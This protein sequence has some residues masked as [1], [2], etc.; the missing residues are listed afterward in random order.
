MRMLTLLCVAL[1]VPTVFSAPPKKEYFLFE[2]SDGPPQLAVPAPRM[3]KEEQQKQLI[4]QAKSKDN[5]EKFKAVTEIRQMLEDSRK[6]KTEKQLIDEFVSA[7]VMDSL[8]DCL[9]YDNRSRRELIRNAMDALAIIA[10]RKAEEILELHNLMDFLI[11]LLRNWSHN[12]DRENAAS[13]LRNIAHKLV[14]KAKS[15]DT[16]DKLEAMTKIREMLENSLKNY[17]MKD[18]SD[19]FI[20]AGVLDLLVHYL[21]EDDP[22]QPQL[23]E[24]AMGALAMIAP[25]KAEK[26]YNAKNNTEYLNFW[27]INSADDKQLKNSAAFI[28]KNIMS[29]LVEQA[30]SKEKDVKLEAVTKIFK[31]LEDSQKHNTDEQLIEEFVSSGVL[32]PLAEC[33]SEDN[34]SQLQLVENSMA[35]LA[36]I[37]PRKAKE[38]YRIPRLYT[39]GYLEYWLKNTTDD[40]LLKNAASILKNIIANDCVH[41]LDYRVFSNLFDSRNTGVFEQAMWGAYH[42]IS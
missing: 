4:K 28:L 19:E 3:G 20:S 37:A 17:A 39:V 16:D 31:A 34:A 12:K 26:I 25:Q 32:A 24:N 40:Q 18:L 7:G 38:I 35:A 1:T 11:Y 23:I 36:I 9:S 2:S 30:K 15:D 6:N 13:I 27:L 5:E 33:L 41:G 10:P 8:A 14:N 29:K 21:S 42:M 22:S